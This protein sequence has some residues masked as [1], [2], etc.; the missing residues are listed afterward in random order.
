MQEQDFEKLGQFYLGK[1]YDLEQSRTLDDLV[2]YDAKD[3]TTHALCVGMTGS[4][5][6]G[7]CISLLEEAAIDNIP[8]LIIDPKG[9]LSN[10]LLT[11]PNLNPA[12]FE[13]WLD[14][15]DAVRKGLSV[16]ELAQKT[17]QQ[18]T[19]GLAEWGQTPDRIR[20]LRE[21]VDVAVYTPGSNI[22]LPLTI[23]RSF[24]APAKEVM[25]NAELLRDRIQATASGLLSLVGI[26]G[27]PLR[28]RE[29]ILLS[30]VLDRAWRCLLYTSRCV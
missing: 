26:T 25:E 18:W 30:T 17:A 16:A 15:A 23:L 8:A 10:L 4:G 27:D 20:R 14:H 5:K 13:P 24:A 6:T 19:E 12:D 1:Q 2:M 11:F 9:D 29:H 28:S 21:A 3:L 22:G 7:L